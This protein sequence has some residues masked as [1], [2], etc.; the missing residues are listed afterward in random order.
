MTSGG[1][2]VNDFPENQLNNKYIVDHKGGGTTTFGGG[3]ANTVGGTVF[4][5]NVIAGYSIRS[6]RDY[7]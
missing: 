6:A 5:L 3:M 7:Q 4:R 2:N 1:N